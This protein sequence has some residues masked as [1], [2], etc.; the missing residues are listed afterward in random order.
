MSRTS[1]FVKGLVST[2][3]QK[4]LTK[5]IGLVVT[6]IVLTYLDKTEYGI[7]VII[8]S[9]LGYVG[10]M[11]FGVTGATS[12]IIA[13]NNTEQNE[14][15]INTIVN[16]AFALQALIGALI[17]VVGFG[18]SFLFPDVFNLEDYSEDKAWM[19]LVMA[20]VGYGISFP[21]KA[22]KGLIR[23]R[24]MISMSVWVEFFLFLSNTAL[25]LILLDLGFGLM[26]LPLGSITLRLLS[27]PLFFI[28]AKKAYA[29]LRFDLSLVSIKSIKEI[30]SFSSLWFVGMIAAMVIYS[31]DA[32]LIGVFLSTASV[33]IY[34]LT[35][36]LSEVIR[37]WIYSISFTLMPGIGQIMGSG[38]KAKA[39]EIYLRTQ[40]VIIALSIVGAGMIYLLN[41]AFVSTWVGSDYFA[42]QALSTVFAAILFVSVVFHSSSLVISADLKIK[43]VTAVRISEALLNILLSIWLIQKYELLGVAIATLIAATLTSFWMVPFITLRYLQISFA[44]WIKKVFSKIFKIMVLNVL[45]IYFF[46]RLFDFTDVYMLLYGL[47]YC[48]INV[49]IIWKISFDDQMKSMILSKLRRKRF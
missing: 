37:E 43:G 47:I 40:P 4:I 3:S 30:V 18:V 8:G 32:I 19:V 22:L 25:N 44:T 17:I 45:I 5:V 49:Y 20:I 26:A 39:Q 38:D 10:L 48:V 28:Y 12:V 21:P 42:G 29:P 13:K 9:V 14:N 11:N 15:H 33:T 34:A 1:R 31:T 46:N 23:A 7:W 6:P 16:N 35:Y 2:T 36:R 24:Q 27:Y 41:N